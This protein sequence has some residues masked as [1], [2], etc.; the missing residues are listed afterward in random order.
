MSEESLIKETSQ[1]TTEAEPQE[2]KDFA[3]AEDQVV[4]PEWLPEKFKT[5]EAFAE[6][7]SHLEKKIGQ[8][9]E[10]YKKAWDA[11][12]Q[13]IAFRDRPASKDEYLLPESVDK[14]LAPENEMLS[15]WSNFAWDNGMSQEEFAKGIE[16]YRNQFTGNEI[17]IEEETKKLGDNAQ[18]RIQAAELWA[19]QFF[20]ADLIKPIL[21]L[22]DSAKGI[23][24]I[25]FI[26]DS[27]KTSSSIETQPANRIDKETIESM[28]QDDRYHNPAKRDPNIVK[29]VNEA[30]AKLHPDQ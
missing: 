15:W 9:E 3:T 2:E 13:E 12:Q 30:W 18:E 29:Q 1:E 8:K 11:E 14:D 26:M 28:M 16:I 27:L 22:A 4:R 21:G 25:E 7:Y 24:A 19:N 10:E 17:N 5:P 6:S 20:G 23:E